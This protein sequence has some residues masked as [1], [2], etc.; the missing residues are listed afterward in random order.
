V[1]LAAENWKDNPATLSWLKELA[2]SSQSLYMC[3]H[4]M[5]AL[6]RGWKQ[7]PAMIDL[8]SGNLSRVDESPLPARLPTVLRWA[9][10]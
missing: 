1:A 7:D 2:Q 5:L 8:D 6:V 4:A 10:L 9:R 3:Q